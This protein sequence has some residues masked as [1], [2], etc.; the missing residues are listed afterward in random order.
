LDLADPTDRQIGVE[1]FETLVRYLFIIGQKSVAEPRLLGGFSAEVSS[2]PN[3]PS[4]TGY[5]N[6]KED[7]PN[8][9]TG[10]IWAVWYDENRWAM[11]MVDGQIYLDT[12]KQISAELKSTTV[13]SVDY[14]TV[15][16]IDTRIRQGSPYDK[17]PPQNSQ[18]KRVTL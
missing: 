17:S 7:F 10:S 18:T 8:G 4:L 12:G 16:Y 15:A 2:G 11:L 14:Q 1:Y 13:K 3:K 6:L 9:F 5:W